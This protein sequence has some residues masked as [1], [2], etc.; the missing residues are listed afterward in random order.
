MYAQIRPVLAL[1]W[2]TLVDQ[3]IRVMKNLNQNPELEYE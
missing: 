3:N 1:K 2:G